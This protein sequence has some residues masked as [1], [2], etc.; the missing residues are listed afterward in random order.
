LNALLEPWIAH[1]KKEL[2]EQLLRTMPPISKSGKSDK[3]AIPQDNRSG[4]DN[5][6]L[7]NRK[8]Q[9]PRKKSG[10]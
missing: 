2:A 8:S 7:V 1:A 9:A 4:T 5:A 6:E 3:E 10:K